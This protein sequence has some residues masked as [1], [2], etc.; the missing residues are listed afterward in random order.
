MTEENK[1]P[2]P[3][4]FGV[5]DT[6]E[7]KALREEGKKWGLKFRGR[8]K[9]EK[10]RAAIDAEIARRSGVQET[11]ESVAEPQPAPT[12]EQTV[13]AAVWPSEEAPMTDTQAAMEEPPK[14]NLK[15]GEK[16][17]MTQ[18][19]W[20]GQQ[21]KAGKQNAGRL[22]RCRI[23]CMN[24]NKKNWTGEIISVGSA[25]IGTFKKFIPFG[26]DQPY[27]IPYIIYQELKER[28]C[29][30]RNVRKEPGGRQIIES[31]MINEFAIEVLT[32]LTAKELEDLRQRQA[33]AKGAA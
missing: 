17:Y 10:M 16:L 9:A 2:L 23:T 19:E 24:P 5:G 1:K 14:I 25:K 7:Q 29:A 26:S 6:D 20:D 15:P 8:P 18:E 31:K 27:H 12:P 13:K 33:M 32:P 21:V 30:I 4:G 22:V 3:P 28:K 11:L